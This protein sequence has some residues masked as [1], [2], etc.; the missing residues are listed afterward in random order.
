MERT[1][2]E[3]PDPSQLPS[4]AIERIFD[5]YI[6]VGVRSQNALWWAQLWLAQQY[7]L[8][9]SAE[10]CSAARRKDKHMAPI[11][12]GVRVYPWPDI[13][14][15]PHPL[16]ESSITLVAGIDKIAHMYAL[17]QEYA[18]VS[19]G[20][21][22]EA[23]TVT[24]PMN[25]TIVHTKRG[26]LTP[27]RLRS[28]LGSEAACSRHGIAVANR[29]IRLGDSKGRTDNYARSLQ[30]VAQIVHSTAN[31]H[32]MLLL[33]DSYRIA[34]P[35]VTSKVDRIAIT[36]KSESPL[37]RTHPATYVAEMLGV[38]REAL[39]SFVASFS[40]HIQLVFERRPGCARGQPLSRANAVVFVRPLASSSGPPYLDDF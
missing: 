28:H 30:E 24:A 26:I 2:Q 37:S 36:M 21:Y 11:A 18:R 8:R 27:G 17:A 6:E 34:D 29:D 3:N 13:G 16:T 19:I 40:P 9:G 23:T 4:L 33:H 35:R 25:I 12:A 1:L 14:H 39:A 15:V 7:H 10:F 38:K 20:R 32:L 22:H 5:H 31:A